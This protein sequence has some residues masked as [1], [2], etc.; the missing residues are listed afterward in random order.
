MSAPANKLVATS[1]PP[2]A[3]IRADFPALDQQVHGHRLAYLDN[4]ASTQ[5]PQAVI[6]ALANFYSH[7]Y[8]NVHRGLHVLSQRATAAYEGARDKVASFIN[9]GAREQIVFTRGTTD[10]INLVAHSFPVDGL[11]PGDE[12]LISQAAHHS[13]IVPWQLAC[14]AA[15]AK[16][17]A[18]PV[19][20]AAELDVEQFKSLLSP[21]TRLVALGHISN[22]TGTINP[23]AQLIDLAHAQDIPVLLDGAQATAHTPIDVQ[24]LGVDFYTFSGHKM[25]GPTGIGVLYAKSD[26][27]EAMPPYQG[28]GDM[29][30]TV[31]LEGSTWAEPPAKFE[32]GTP[33]IAGAVGLGAAIDYLQQFDLNTIAA[34]EHTLLEAA[35]AQLADIPG[36]R[37]IGTAH[38]KSAIISFVMDGAHPQDIGTLLDQ[39]GVAVRT[40]HHCAMPLMQR[41]GVAGTARAS[42]AL[43]ND[44]QDVEALANGLHKIQRMLG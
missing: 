24:A 26:L 1:H 41:F 9:A 36:L 28:G 35:T 38:A 11:Q 33:N 31:T 19:N 17:V 14:E 12:I 13:N 43:Y 10:A 34:H 8:A 30:D 27:L 44:M 22:A 3:A 5:K 15:G 40:G 39:N 32:A 29:I 16:T 23:V 18:V 20:D 6:D 37:I 25:F 4:A 7:D 2:V 42:F 21:R